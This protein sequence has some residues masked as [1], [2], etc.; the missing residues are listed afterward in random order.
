MVDGSCNSKLKY[1][2]L[3]HN[4]IASFQKEW[5]ILMVHAYIIFSSLKTLSGV[6]SKSPTYQDGLWNDD[7]DNESFTIQEVGMD[8]DELSPLTTLAK[9][10]TTPLAFAA[11]Y[12]FW[13][14][15]I[16]QNCGAFTYSDILKCFD[17][18]RENLCEV[19]H[20]LSPTLNIE[21]CP[22]RT[23]ISQF[24][25]FS[26]RVCNYTACLDSVGFPIPPK[27]NSVFLQKNGKYNKIITENDFD[28]ENNDVTTDTFCIHPHNNLEHIDVSNMNLAA[29]QAH[30]LPFR[31]EYSVTGFTK[32]KFLNVQGCKLSLV[33]KQLPSP[34]M[35]ALTD[36]HIGGNIL[37]ANDILPADMFQHQTQLSVLNLS[38]ANLQGIETNT[39]KNQHHL[40]VLD[41]SY[42]QLN[43]SS[44][45]SLDLSTNTIKRLNL[46]HNK[47]T[48]MPESFREQLNSM[49]GLELNLA[50]NTF[51]CTCDNLEFLRWVQSRRPTQSTFHHKVGNAC[52]DSPGNT[53]HSIALDSLYC[54]WYWMQPVI[55]ACSSV[56]VLLLVLGIVSLYKKRF[57]IANLIFR[58]KE[59]LCMPSDESSNVSYR[60]DAFVLY[61]SIDDDRLFVHFKLVHELEKVY[62]FL[63][64]IHHRD[65]LAGCDI[66]DNIEQAIRSSRKVL[67][68]MSENFFKE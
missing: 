22:K 29:L 58:L 19:F 23:T 45:V 28:P 5:E 63:L 41:L 34:D 2:N 37:S 26:Q 17:Q 40:S 51:I 14:Q 32:L 30:P 61:S 48:A 12:E 9:F 54:E 57:F 21:Y 36:L 64:C 8:D 15:D 39:F 62:G 13:L 46:S 1:L 52:T 42:N 53:I 50:G 4:D 55:M 47:L 56:S 35:K 16:M 66:L 7:T 43:L 25:F 49:E 31:F 38:N 11:E 44:L 3:D 60:Y 18:G 68:I 67:V 65:F 10:Q 24:T 33:R 6:T 20:C 27:L 59:R